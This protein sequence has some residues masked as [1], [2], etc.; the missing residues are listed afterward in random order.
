MARR[1]NRCNGAADQLR[2]EPNAVGPPPVE[3]KRSP[4]NF[5]LLM[6]H[7]KTLVIITLAVL[8]GCSENK[9]RKVQTQRGEQN[10][11]TKCVALDSD[12]TLVFRLVSPNEYEIDYPDFYVLET[13]VTNAQFKAYLVATERTKDDSD[14]LNI[15]KEREKSHVFSTGDIPYRI[16]D[17][18]TIWRGG[19]YPDGL[20]DHPVALVTLHDATGFADWLNQ[21]HGETG[22]FRLP[23]WNEWVIAAY[24]KS[25]NYPW[26]N[27]WDRKHLHSSYGFK[28]DFDFLDNGAEFKTPPK[29]TEHVKAR[30]SGRTPEGVFGM[31]GNVGEY[32]IE[33]DPTGDSYFNLGSRSM[34]GGFTDGLAILHDENDRL[35]PRNDYWG[36]SH[37][38][39][40]RESDLGFRLVFAPHNNAEMLKHPRLFP[41]NNPAWMTENDHGVESKQE[42]EAEQTDEP[43]PE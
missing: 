9:P 13:E 42:S 27:V 40:P 37:H 4:S 32:I 35:P 28:L 36:Y 5:K 24:G 34:G 18:S 7:A 11:A 26:G 20:Q 38:A 43:E 17:E 8:T 16:E 33:G 15:I 3:L 31:L 25:R 2:P 39:T 1:T 10:V 23:T 21:T 22:V 14:V 19:N 41:Q 12:Q 30:P 6:A 29:R